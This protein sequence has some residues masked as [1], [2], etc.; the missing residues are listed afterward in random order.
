[1]KSIF[2]GP[3]WVAFATVA[4]MNASVAFAAQTSITV[5]MQLEP[6]NLD[7]T[8]GAAAAIDEVVY[9][10]V[11]EGLTRYQADGS[12]APA[13]AKSWMISDD[14]LVYT[15]SLHDGVTFHDGSAMDAADVKFSLDRARAEDSTNAQKRLFTGIA[16]VDVVNPLTVKITL[17]NPDGGFITNLAWGCLLYTSDAADE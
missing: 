12:V 16:S 3:T 14:G 1:M 6:P 15:F 11:F 9:A 2:T 17:S 13:L 4:A 7:P 10:N 8:G 5:G